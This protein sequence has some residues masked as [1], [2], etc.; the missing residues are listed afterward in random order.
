MSASTLDAWLASY[1]ANRDSRR[2]A[3]A[4][5]V[6][7]LANAALQVRKSIGEG[8][9]GASFSGTCGNAN[10]G[11]DVQ[12]D[13]DVHADRIFLAAMRQAPVAFYASEEL[14]DPITLDVTQPIALAIDPLDG[15]SNIDTNTSIGTIFS[16]LPSSGDAAST[17]L[18][19]GRMQLGAG[20]FIFGP[21]FALVLT[22]GEGTRIFVLSA[23]LG[24]FVEAYPSLQIAPDATEFAVNASNYRHWDEAV[25]L[26]V[27][28]CIQGVEGPRGKDFNMRW[29]GVVT[30]SFSGWKGQRLVDIQATQAAIFHASKASSRW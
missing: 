4:A 9:L 27:D 16:I 5:T 11:G 3:V 18:Q 28:D 22:L 1:S 17:F 10:A 14:D 13:L 19:P 2:I 20:F 15:S 30:L 21:Q 23:R 8:A 29:I 26:Y 6:R 7:H 12:K 25:R 24:T